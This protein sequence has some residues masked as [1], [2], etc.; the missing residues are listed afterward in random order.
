MFTGTGRDQAVRISNTELKATSHRGVV[1]SYRHPGVNPLK[2][3]LLRDYCNTG[4][5]LDVGC[6]NGL[7]ALSCQDRCP[8]VIQVDLE[9]RRDPQA[10]NF[11]F[12]AMN[13]EDLS[14]LNGPFDNIIAFDI[15]E[16]LDDD[17]GFLKEAYR[18][19]GSGGRLFLSVP[20]EDNSLLEK[21]NLA[22]IHFTDKTHRREYSYAGLK[23]IL[24]D[25]H[26]KNVKISPHIN[27]SVV[28]IPQ[29]LQKENTISRYM[30]KFFKI[31][32]RCCEKIGIFENRIIAD[33]FAVVEK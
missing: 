23:S 11:T 16:H 17:V 14:L 1:R 29:L 9:D 33:W 5:L 12:Y 19:L 27:S 4:S 25:G 3:Q 15:I 24:E 10:S 6:G 22:H 8:E 21:L 13:A 26:F 28:N 30:A 7:Y 32:M 2:S 20:N 31:Q 18:L